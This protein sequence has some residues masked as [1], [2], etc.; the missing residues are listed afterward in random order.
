MSVDSQQGASDLL[1]L[2]RRKG[3]SIDF[4]EGR[5]LVTV[6]SFDARIA[7]LEFSN[8][9]WKRP[10]RRR[11]K[12]G[13]SFQIEEGVTVIVTRIALSKL[14]DETRPVHVRLDIKAPLEIEIW[15]SELLEKHGARA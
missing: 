5:I 2:T 1:S 11:M 13:D 7:T 9:D 8:T 10:K 12:P 14:N 3:E 15:R 4:D 6:L